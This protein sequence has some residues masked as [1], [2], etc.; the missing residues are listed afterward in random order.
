MRLKHVKGA[1]EII[2]KGT[3]YIENPKEYKG[4][5]NKVFNNNNPIY[6]EIGM[7]K[8]DFIIE[9]A[10]KYPEINFIGIEKFDSVIVRAIQKSNELELYNL[11]LIRMDAM[12]IEEVFNKEIDRIYLNFS[13]PWPKERHAKRRLTSPIFLAKYDLIFKSSANIIM[14]TDNNPLFEY[15]LET[16][17]EAGYELLE[18]T[19]DLYSEDIADNIATEYEKKFVSR[20]ININRL[21]GIKPKNN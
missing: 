7:G 3:Y 9:N 19:R 11:K 14:K 8:G 18:V 12:E 21:Y 16:L 2:K 10:L 5:W 1:E 17:K 15:S 6:I 20:G 4:S 13:D